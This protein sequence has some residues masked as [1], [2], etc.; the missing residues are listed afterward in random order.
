[1]AE[2]SYWTRAGAHLITRRQV[3]RGAALGGAGL[4][5]AALL[6]CSGDEDQAA[7]PPAGGAPAKAGTAAPKS[8]GRVVTF[9]NGDPSSIDMHVATSS[10]TS[11]PIGPA[12]M[13]LLQPDPHI[14]VESSKTI[15]AALAKSWEVSPDGQTYTF[16]LVPNA[17]FHDGVPFTS[18]DAKTTLERVQNPP[19]GVVSARKLQLAGAS[20][21]TPD[22][23]TL[24]IK[25]ATRRAPATLLGVLAQGWMAVYSQKDMAGGFDFTKQV[26]G[27]G[28][29]K[30]VEYVTGNRVKMDKYAG[31]HNAPYP[32]PDGTDIFVIPEAQAALAQ[33]QAGAIHHG[34]VDR[35]DSHEAMK[36]AIG[37]K[38]SYPALVKP[39]SSNWHFNAKNA[40]YS[41]HR[42][43]LALASAIDVAEANQ[44]IEKGA[45]HIGGIML[46]GGEWSPTLEEIQKI[47]GWGPVTSTTLAESKKLLAAAGVPDGF[48]L[49]VMA[50]SEQKDVPVVV[51]QQ[52]SKIGIKGTVVVLER[53]T[54]LEKLTAGQFDIAGDSGSY[55]T[56]DPDSIFES[57]FLKDSP[58][59]YSRLDSKDWDHLFTQQSSELDPQ[60][61]LDLV[62]QMQKAAMANLG[63]KVL[64]WSNQFGVVWNFVKGYTVH[65]ITHNNTR[66]EQ[67]WLDR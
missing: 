49:G 10:N 6:G 7:P 64:Y 22:A 31:Y 29:Y 44:V 67:V 25:T 28:P 54:W 16:K 27:L 30:F 50:R 57:S 36:K 21:T 12:H 1:M 4:A 15:V 19:Q 65:G 43:R 51:V 48:P 3:V 41:D 26:N 56:D 45:A 46:P 2:A 53:T 42:V 35:L 38:A 33:L 17:K 5:A 37:D 8:G 32:Y 9:T 60:K 13:G 62:K 14:A 59:N 18:A 66:G 23:T 11:I 58:R 39:S 63:M 61:R 47:P 40:P 52:L 20:F 24:V 55:T 34:L